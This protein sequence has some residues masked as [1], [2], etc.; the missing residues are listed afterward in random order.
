M[1]VKLLIKEFIEDMEIKGK[2]KSTRRV[3]RN[4]LLRFNNWL[5]ENNINDIE[6]INKSVIKRYIIYLQ[7][8]KL[9]HQFINTTIKQLKSFYNFLYEEEYS[10]NIMKDIKSVK[11][12]KKVISTFDLNYAK[13]ISTLKGNSFLEIRNNTII[14]MLLET[15]MRVTELHSIKLEDVSATR[16][17]IHGKGNKQRYIG[18]SSTLRKAIKRYIACRNEYMSLDFKEC[19]YLFISINK[20][21][22]TTEAV[23]RLLKQTAKK[24][25]LEYYP[26]HMFRR[27]YCIQMLKN[28]VDYYTLSRLVGH[29]TIT[30]L[31]RYVHSME[32]EEILSIS[33][34]KTPL[35][36]K[37]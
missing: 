10:L 23:E 5:I 19:D 20:R 24:R 36:Y 31:Q 11:E 12:E 14:V 29:S 28:G 1:N 9:T 22:L 25:G 37:K 33:K 2:A 26:P 3:Y 6:E 17:L 4:S 13:K 7:K 35:E 16:I 18:I 15:G 27:F 34:G 8:K 21:K 30:T 32:N